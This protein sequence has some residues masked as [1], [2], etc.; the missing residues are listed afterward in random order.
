[1]NVDITLDDGWL[2]VE[3]AGTD[4]NSGTIRKVFGS[5]SSKE[6]ARVIFAASVPF[7][8]DEMR[9][10]CVRSSDVIGVLE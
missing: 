6:N 9:F 1:M 8:A 5:S 7:K 3:V 10:V 4:H 2:L